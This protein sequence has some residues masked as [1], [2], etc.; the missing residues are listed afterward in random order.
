VCGDAPVT[1]Q[2]DRQCQGDEFLGDHVEGAGC[3]GRAAQ[4]VERLIHLGNHLAKGATFL[5]EGL[6]NLA[7]VAVFGHAHSVSNSGIDGI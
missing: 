3:H 7:S 4:V 5:V 6:Q 2:A 1:A